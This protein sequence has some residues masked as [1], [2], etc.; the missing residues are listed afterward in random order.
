MTKST[1]KQEEQRL[2]LKEY[3]AWRYWISLEKRMIATHQYCSI[4]EKNKLAFSNEYAQII[5]LS[6]VHFES[7]AK[8]L[9][10]KYGGAE[11]NKANLGAI[12]ECLM[13]KR[14]GMADY[15]LTQFPSMQV[16]Q[17][18]KEWSEGRK[19][20]WW[21]KYTK[22][23]HDLESARDCATQDVALNA[24]SGCLVVL[25]YLLEGKMDYIQP[26][27]ELILYERSPY[28]VGKSPL[29]LP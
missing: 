19:A 1:T 29:N 9:V 18:L 11:R 20:D 15:K 28:L 21:E 3:E 24:L 13:A 8:V 26:H 10:D 2:Q 17:P 22:I 14:P 12:R 27:S 16:M 5:L 7:C 4:H 23:K 25:L 6:A